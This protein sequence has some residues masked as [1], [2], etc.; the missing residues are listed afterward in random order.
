ML[1]DLHVLCQTFIVFNWSQN[2]VIEKMQLRV[3]LTDSKTSVS[4]HVGVGFSC[5]LSGPE[6]WP[7]VVRSRLHHFLSGLHLVGVS[8]MSCEESDDISL[9]F[10]CEGESTQST[11]GTLTKMCYC[12]VNLKMT[13]H[14][15]TSENARW[16]MSA[17]AINLFLSAVPE[18]HNHLT[19]VHLYH[20][21]SCTHTL[22]THIDTSIVNKTNLNNSQI[23]VNMNSRS[24]SFFCTIGKK[25]NQ[26]WSSTSVNVWTFEL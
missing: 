2:S 12:I 13:M 26:V 8:L 23:N 24:V 19:A 1:E 6:I 9:S 16:F 7:S 22:Q 15:K 10:W 18:S 17:S 5:Q 14:K 21:N 11:P 3:L 20:T 4:C 25:R